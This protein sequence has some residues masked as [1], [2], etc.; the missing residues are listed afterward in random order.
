MRIKITENVDHLYAAGSAKGM[1]LKTGAQYKDFTAQS[2]ALPSMTN[3]FAFMDFAA[4]K[5][6]EVE[7]DYLFDDQFNVGDPPGFVPPADRDPRT[8]GA[9]VALRFV[10]AIDFAPEF[11]GPEDYLQVAAKRRNADWGDGV[12][13][14][15]RELIN[16]IA[17]GVL[18]DETKPTA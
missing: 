18:K 17:C 8:T 5:W 13:P 3:W 14:G 11:K 12:V 6:V 10:D 1:G 16:R 7:T 15:S 9:R 2:R 4:G